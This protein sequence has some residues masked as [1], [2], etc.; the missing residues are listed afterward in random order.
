VREIRLPR[1]FDITAVTAVAGELV[2][3]FTEGDVT[4]DASAVVKIDAAALQLMCV[5]VATAR[6]QRTQLTWQGVPPVITEGAHLL[7]L[8]DVL[9]FERLRS[10]ENR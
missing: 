9:G 7:A 10:Q 8:T 3:A 1:A 5:A 2:Q 6:H 4:V